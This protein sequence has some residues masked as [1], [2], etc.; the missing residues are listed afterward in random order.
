LQAPSGLAVVD[1]TIAV[2]DAGNARIELFDA[3]GTFLE[4][5][6]VAQWAELAAP[7]ADVAMDAGGTIWASSPATNEILVFRPDGSLAGNLVGDGDGLDRPLGLA[8]W[9]GGLLFVASSGGNRI[10]LLTAINP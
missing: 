3:D 1:G 5:I 7:E 6:P 4:A 8:L 2:A 10:S 9:P